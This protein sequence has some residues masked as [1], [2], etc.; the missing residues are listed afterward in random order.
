VCV[1]LENGRIETTGWLHRGYCKVGKM[2]KK[3]LKY[4][5]QFWRKHKANEVFKAQK[6]KPLNILNVTD[7]R[8]W[9][10]QI[11]ISI[12]WRKFPLKQRTTIGDFADGWEVYLVVQGI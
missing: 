6:V 10:K 7:I 2:L 5:K 3:F 12:K 8:Q 1:Y 9:G 11:K 4:S